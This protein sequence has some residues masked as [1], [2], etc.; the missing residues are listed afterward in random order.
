MYIGKAV[1]TRIQV[2]R[3]I[4]ARRLARLISCFPETYTLIP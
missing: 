1:E 2:I 4:V 3:E